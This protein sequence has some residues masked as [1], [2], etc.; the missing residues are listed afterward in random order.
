MSAPTDPDTHDSGE[1][2]RRLEEAQAFSEH[3]A[4]QLGE[5]VLTLATRLEEIASRL[6]RLER[7]IETLASGPEPDEDASAP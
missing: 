2:L 1:R 3:A 5:Q 6:A 7:R 4:E